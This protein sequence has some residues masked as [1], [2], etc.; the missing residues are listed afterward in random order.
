M[1]IYDLR[2]LYIK[3]ILKTTSTLE[4]KIN[5]L[6]KI[7]NNIILNINQTSDIELLVGGSI[8][9]EKVEKFNG[10]VKEIDKLITTLSE[11]KKIYEKVEKL[12]IEN[13]KEENINN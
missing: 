4:K 9:L 6:N 1:E 10:F 2:N 3:N 8:A 5:L 12:V 11:T 7:N 13:K